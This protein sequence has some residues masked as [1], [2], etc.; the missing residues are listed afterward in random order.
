V[1][2]T[3]VSIPTRA[4]VMGMVRSDRVLLPEE[5]YPVARACGLG[6]EQVRSCLRR[7]VAEGLLVRKGAGRPARF[8]ATGKALEA[9][10]SRSERFRFAYRLDRGHEPWDGLWH[11]VAFAIPESRRAARDRFRL[12]LRSMG[13]AQMQG[14]LYVSPHPWEPA[15]RSEAA[16]LGVKQLV[17][18]AS[19]PDLEVGGIRDPRRIARVLWPVDELAQRYRAFLEAYRGVTPMLE[20]LRAR[21]D[22]LSDEQFL[23]GALEMAVVFAA[24][25]EVDPLLPPEL[26]PARWPGSQARELLLRGRCLALALREAQG[27]PPLFESFDQTLETYSG[28]PVAELV[29]S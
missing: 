20:S 29:A 24:S 16:E 23:A 28:A 9:L 8:L 25:F 21:G 26:L 17:I 6:P 2:E 3:T 15:V 14:G 10:E 4:L 27:R 1:K 19:S 22:S 18:A 5:V 13:G 7:L 11:L 12:R